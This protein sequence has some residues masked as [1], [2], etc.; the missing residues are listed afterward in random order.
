M[1]LFRKIEERKKNYWKEIS[2]RIWLRIQ[3]FK[4]YLLWYKNKNFFLKNIKLF[5]DNF[6]IYQKADSIKKIFNK[7]KSKKSNEIRNCK[8]LAKYFIFKVRYVKRKTIDKLIKKPKNFISKFNLLKILEN[9]NKSR[10]KEPLAS[11]IGKTIF[12]EGTVI[13]LDKTIEHITTLL[14]ECEKCGSYFFFVL[15]A[16]NELLPF[17]CNKENCSS[18]KFFPHFS[19]VLTEN[20]QKLKL[21]K[22]SINF[23]KQKKNE[24]VLLNVYR[25]KNISFLKGHRIFCTAEIKVM[26]ISKKLSSILSKKNL[27]NIQMHVQ[28][29]KYSIFKF[30]VNKSY[31]FLST[32]D[33][34]FIN[35][36]NSVANLFH[37]LIKNIQP[38]YCGYE[39]IKA[40]LLLLASQQLQKPKECFYFDILN[41]CFI[42]SENSDSNDFFI[43]KLVKF[44]PRC[45]ILNFESFISQIN[46]RMRNKSYNYVGSYLNLKNSIIFIDL[47]SAPYKNFNLKMITQKIK[48]FLKK[49]KSIIAPSIIVLH[50]NLNKKNNIIKSNQYRY[51]SKNQNVKNFLDLIYILKK[52]FNKTNGEIKTSQFFE[53]NPL[54]KKTLDLNNLNHICLNFKTSILHPLLLKKKIS[55]CFFKKYLHFVQGF[56]DSN[57]TTKS[58][59]L[60]LNFYKKIRSFKIYSLNF[61]LEFLSILIKFSQCRAKIDL[62]EQICTDDILDGL[63][64]FLDSKPAFFKNLLFKTINKKNKANEKINLFYKF[65]RLLHKFFYTNGQTIFEIEELEKNLRNKLKFSE[66]LEIFRVFN[67]IKK[68]KINLISLNV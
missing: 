11:L 8:S 24:S 41:F 59:D 49:K 3:I 45:F 36:I 4:R 30:V 28:N 1:K 22:I 60:L 57:L 58:L 62:R 54:K 20:F 46:N 51:F 19:R 38:T 39:G 15:E 43:K 5:F 35:K 2:F 68:I 9:E 23:K 32:S 52:S 27:F 37:L 6:P 66:I 44:F 14:V 18:K 29:N 40:C 25:S 48:K 50:I 47:N 34:L 55:A 56:P 65:L 13:K 53:H 42:F 64:I 21:G 26:P 31:F 67:M 10:I 17:I 61:S 63:E 16:L 12:L 33:F 7:I